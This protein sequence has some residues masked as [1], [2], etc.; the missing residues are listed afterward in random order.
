MALYYLLL[1]GWVVFGHSEIALRSLSVIIAV[2]SLWVV[3]MLARRLFGPR[4]ALLAGLLFAVNPLFVQFAQDARGYS[5]ALLFVSASCYFFVRG[6]QQ[7]DPPPR[8]CWTAF[9]VVTALAA[10]CNFWAALVPV[11]QALSLAFLPAGPDPVAPHRGV[12]RGTGRAARPA[13]L[14]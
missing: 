6:I 4:A 13:R 7:G 8:F 5:L 11:G 3:I 10:Y 12:G 1:R 9:T 2:G 14:C